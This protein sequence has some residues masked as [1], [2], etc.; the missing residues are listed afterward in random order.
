MIAVEV[1]QLSASFLKHPDMWM[2]RELIT[3]LP[4]QPVHTC[5]IR[6]FPFLLDY[7]SHSLDLPW[8]FPFHDPAR[9]CLRNERIASRPLLTALGAK[10]IGTASTQRSWSGTN[11]YPLSSCPTSSNRQLQRYYSHHFLLIDSIYIIIPNNW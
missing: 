10:I 9:D 8:S 4:S 3:R 2:L 5:N 11:S 6:T 7:Y 1:S